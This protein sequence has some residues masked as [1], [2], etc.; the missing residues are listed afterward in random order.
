MLLKEC[1]TKMLLAAEFLVSHKS[2]SS[3]QRKH[4]DGDTS[5]SQVP[6]ELIS[7]GESSQGQQE[8]RILKVE[9]SCKSQSKIFAPTGER[10][11]YRR[12]KSGE[13]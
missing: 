13:Y 2:Q 8:P 7:S 3:S 10:D 12:T 5:A 6:Y 9:D 1:T 11:D 4:T